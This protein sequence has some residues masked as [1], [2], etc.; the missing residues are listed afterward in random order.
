[1]VQYSDNSFGNATT[2]FSTNVIKDNV[3]SFL[4]TEPFINPNTAEKAKLMFLTVSQ[5][6]YLEEFGETEIDGQKD[7]SLKNPKWKLLDRVEYNKIKATKNNRIICRI[8]PWNSGVFDTER[9]PQNDLPTYDE[10]F[11]LETDNVDIPDDARYIP[12]LPQPRLLN[13]SNRTAET[14][15]GGQGSATQSSPPPPISVSTNW[16]IDEVRTETQV[17]TQTSQTRADQLSNAQA[18]TQTSQTRSDQLSN[19]QVE[20]NRNLQTSVESISISTG[21]NNN[22]SSGGSY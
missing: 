11:I 13:E 19:A 5:V 20:T 16:Y 8:R 14:R 18:E 21:T 10:Y 1:L 7:K 9:N 4:G 22:P 12:P 15:T 2:S 6:E 3:F 17:Q